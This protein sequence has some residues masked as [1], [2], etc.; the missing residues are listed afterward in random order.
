MNNSTER[1]TPFY[2][3]IIGMEITIVNLYGRK[4]MEKVLIGDHWDMTKIR[5]TAIIITITLEEFIFK[6]ERS[7]VYSFWKDKKTLERVNDYL[8]FD[9]SPEETLSEVRI[10]DYDKLPKFSKNVFS[11]VYVL[12]PLYKNNCK[13]NNIIDWEIVEI[14]YL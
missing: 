5:R 11:K 13:F 8:G 3:L 6:L 2:I 1:S 4:V 14:R 10:Q 7:R 12:T 9:L